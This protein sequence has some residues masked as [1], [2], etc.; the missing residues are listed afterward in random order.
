[1]TIPVER[2]RKE[3]TENGRE[4]AGLNVEGR[5]WLLAGRLFC[6]YIHLKHFT[7]IF[8]SSSNIEHVIIPSILHMRKPT[9]KK[10]KG[11]VQGHITMGSRYCGPSL[12]TLCNKPLLYSNFAWV[13][14]WLTSLVTW[15][16]DVQVCV[17]RCGRLVITSASVWQRRSVYKITLD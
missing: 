6:F 7:N 8:S 1:M 16:I 12:S 11:L 4:G 15:K 17:H 14:P 3:K 13:W 5:P 10:E 9:F 2:E